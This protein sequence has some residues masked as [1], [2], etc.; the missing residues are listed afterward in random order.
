MKRR[1]K[2]EVLQEKLQLEHT[3]LLFYI[4]EAAEAIEGLSAGQI[5][6]SN[7]AKAV[8]RLDSLT[9]AEEYLSKTIASLER[10]IMPTEVFRE[11]E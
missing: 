4:D 5:Y 3:R 10:A 8:Q 11:A 6:S 7:G 9:S 1:D 2:L